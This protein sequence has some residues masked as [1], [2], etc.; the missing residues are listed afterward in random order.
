MKNLSIALS[1]ICVG[2]FAYSIHTYNENYRL[3]LV[4]YLSR[5]EI[6]LLTYEKD[7]LEKRPTYED[8]YKSALIKTGGPQ[9]GGAYNEGW[10]DAQKVYMSEG[11]TTGY[12]NCLVQF[13]YQKPN[14]T[15]Y[16][17]PEPKNNKEDTTAKVGM[18]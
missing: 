5:E 15:R 2:L 17:A 18:K 10:D 12:H 9:G 7:E 1:I 16:L 14:T 6:R 11:Y 13:G 4:N 8:G 3:K